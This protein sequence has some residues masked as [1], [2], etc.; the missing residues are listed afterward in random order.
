MTSV[1]R[2]ELLPVASMMDDVRAFAKVV[3]EDEKSNKRISY[4]ERQCSSAIRTNLV[5]REREG[6][7]SSVYLLAM[8]DE[9]AEKVEDFYKPSIPVRCRPDCDIWNFVS[10]TTVVSHFANQQRGRDWYAL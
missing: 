10:C 4:Y 2:E 3:V 1:N 5:F 8:N 7:P 9:L 6:E